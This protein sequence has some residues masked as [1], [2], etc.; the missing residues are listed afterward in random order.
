MKHGYL[1]L[2][3]CQTEYASTCC[4]FEHFNKAAEKQ[5]YGRRIFIISLRHAKFQSLL[6]NSGDDVEFIYFLLSLHYNRIVHR[7]LGVGEIRPVEV[8]RGGFRVFGNG[9]HELGDQVE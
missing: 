2:L 5:Q 9:T 1:Y 8:Q 3:C 4:T 7:L 6:S